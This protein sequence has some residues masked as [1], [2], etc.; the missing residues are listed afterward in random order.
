LL[1]SPAIDFLKIEIYKMKD[2]FLILGLLSPIVHGGEMNSWECS[3]F[4]GAKIIGEDGDYLGR[5]GPGYNS[6][7]IFNSSI[8]GMDNLY[9]IQ[10]TKYYFTIYYHSKVIK[11]IVQ[12]IK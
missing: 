1:P 9:P 3:S 8:A 2:V 4:E 5:L 11:I 12:I 10:S 7:S 6:D